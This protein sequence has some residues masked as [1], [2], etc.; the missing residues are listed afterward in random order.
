MPLLLGSWEIAGPFSSSFLSPL[1][2]QDNHLGTAFE[3]ELRN[4]LG[5]TRAAAPRREEHVGKRQAG[6]L[7]YGR[8]ATEVA[9]DLRPTLIER[10]ANNVHAFRPETGGR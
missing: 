10:S 9:S 7:Y 8:V 3:V 5:A 2:K 1:A 4:N 6:A